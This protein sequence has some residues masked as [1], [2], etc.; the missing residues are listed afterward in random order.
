MAPPFADQYVKSLRHGRDAVDHRAFGV[1]DALKADLGA[2]LH[3]AAVRIGELEDGDTRIEDEIGL[4]ARI[5]GPG[6]ADLAR[7]EFHLH[8]IAAVRDHGAGDGRVGHGLI[9]RVIHWP[10]T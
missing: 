2:G 3:D 1:A 10:L 7:P 4:T 9:A 6:S 5:C 8:D